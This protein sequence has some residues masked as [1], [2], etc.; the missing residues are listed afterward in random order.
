MIVAGVEYYHGKI[1]RSN[2]SVSVVIIFFEVYIFVAGADYIVDSLCCR[3]S[4]IVAFEVTE[5]RR[6]RKRY[7]YGNH[8]L[9]RHSVIGVIY[10][11]RIEPELVSRHFL[12]E[13]HHRTAVFAEKS[14]ITVLRL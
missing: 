7:R 11:Y 14:V 3:T 1:V 4:V 6:M 12:V 5:R 8:A 13:I 10:L 9:F 2:D